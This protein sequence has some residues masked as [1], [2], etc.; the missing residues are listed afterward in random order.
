MKQTRAALCVLLCLALLAPC[1]ALAQ[2][3]PVPQPP[4]SVVR[5]VEL[6]AQMDFWALDKR[7]LVFCVP[8]GAQDCYL[9]VCDGHAMM[10]DCASVGRAPVTDYLFRLLKAL[11]IDKLDYALNTHPHRDHYNGFAELLSAVPTDEF[12]TVFP[13]KYDKFQRQL[14]RDVS[15]TGVPIREYVPGDPLPLGDAIISTYRFRRSKNVNDLSLVVRVQYGERAVLLTADILLK[16]Q[17][18]MAQEY[19]SLWKADI[20]KLPHHGIGGLAKELYDTVQ[21]EICFASNGETSHSV[22][23]M[24]KFL[25]KRGTPLFFTSRRALALLTD[26]RTWEVQ[27]WGEDSIQL[28]DYTYVPEPSV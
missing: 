1:A 6:P 20:L 11:H 12:L 5:V 22:K 13:L 2:S 26:G 8:V 24:R 18:K 9:V 17:R 4:P 25:E 10:V 7:L 28:P 19:G 15:A 27:Q 14:I 3:A 21:P 16:A 23:L